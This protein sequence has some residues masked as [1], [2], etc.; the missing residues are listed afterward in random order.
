MYHPKRI[1]TGGCLVCG[2]WNRGN[3]CIERFATL[4]IYI[5]TPSPYGQGVPYIAS[6]FT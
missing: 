3:N 2:A 5:G 1:I 6:F 4:E